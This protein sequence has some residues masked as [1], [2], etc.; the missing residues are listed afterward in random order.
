MCQELKTYGTIDEKPKTDDLKERD[1]EKK[2]LPSETKRN[3]PNGKRATRIYNRPRRGTKMP[4]DTQTKTV[5][6]PDRDRNGDTAPK[7]GWRVRDLVPAPGK[8][9]KRGAVRE[10]R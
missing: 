3:N 1:R 4:G 9:E 2:P 5:K 10:L 8:V 7:Y 6:K